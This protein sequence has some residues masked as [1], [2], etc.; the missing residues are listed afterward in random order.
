MSDDV[1]RRVEQKQE[2]RYSFICVFSYSW[3]LLF[4]HGAFLTQTILEARSGGQ[5]SPPGTVGKNKIKNDVSQQAQSQRHKHASDSQK[6][7]PATMLVPTGVSG[8]VYGDKTKAACSPQLMLDAGWRG[9]SRFQKGLRYQRH[10]VW[11]DSGALEAKKSKIQL[12]D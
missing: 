10:K 6:D 8:T 7:T 3:K 11:T 12:A 5:T 9:W 4:C 1:K 2:A